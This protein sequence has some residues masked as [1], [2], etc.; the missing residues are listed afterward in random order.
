MRISQL[1]GEEEIFLPK[2]LVIWQNHQT[3]REEGALGVEVVQTEV[4]LEVGVVQTEVVLEAGEV[5]TEAAS[6]VEVVQIEE[7]LVVE[8]DQ[9]EGNLEA[10]VVGGEIKMVAGTTVTLVKISPLAGVV[11][12]IPIVRSRKVTMVLS[13]GIKEAGIRAS[14][15]AGIQVP[16]HPKVLLQ[17]VIQ[18]VVGLARGRAGTKSQEL[19][20]LVVVV[21]HKLEVGTKDLTLMK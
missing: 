19:I 1:A 15:R 5:P 10:E 2:K 4:I 13:V 7:D 14:G 17:L 8:A 16:M 21:V 18:L 6:G 12:A 9:V 3:G 11:E 20:K